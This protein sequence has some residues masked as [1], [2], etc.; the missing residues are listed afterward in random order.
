MLI[1]FIFTG[2]IIWGKKFAFDKVWNI[3]EFRGSPQWASRRSLHCLDLSAA[4]G[5]A[6]LDANFCQ[7]PS[8]RLTF[9]SIMEAQLKAPIESPGT[10]LPWHSGG[11]KGCTFKKGIQASW[12]VVGLIV[13]V[14]IPYGTLVSRRSMQCPKFFHKRNAS[15]AL[16]AVAGRT[17]R[18]SYC[19]TSSNFLP[20][21]IRRN[22]FQRRDE[23]FRRLFVRLFWKRNYRWRSMELERPEKAV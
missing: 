1:N 6:L 16:V 19:C 2:Y 7:F 10:I 4:I 20:K 21:T 12:A 11:F 14:E 8:E 5:S 23:P 18:V 22:F 15:L 3:F 17:P 9:L 13:N